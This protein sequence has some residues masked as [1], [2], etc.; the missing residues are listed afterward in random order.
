MFCVWDL[1]ENLLHISWVR[2]PTCSA[3]GELKYSCLLEFQNDKNLLISCPTEHIAYG[4]D[5]WYNIYLF[6][7]PSGNCMNLLPKH[8]FWS[9][10]ENIDCFKNHFWLKTFS[11]SKQ[12]QFYSS[13]WHVD[14]W[15]KRKILYFETIVPYIGKIE[16]WGITN[17]PLSRKS[18]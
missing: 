4:L 5:L 3:F 14:H 10:G 16:V 11:G 7:E 2:W 1:Q 13:G 9:C 8:H 12:I 18:S 15:S 6:K 17:L